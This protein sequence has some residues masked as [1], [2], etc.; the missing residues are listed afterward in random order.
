MTEISFAPTG[1]ALANEASAVEGGRNPPE[2]AWIWKTFRTGNDPTKFDRLF[3]LLFPPLF[4]RTRRLFPAVQEAD[5]EDAVI[6][7]LT[8]LAFNP[9]RYDEKR[10]T[11]LSFLTLVARRR[12]ID[13]IRRRKKEFMGV[14]FSVADGLSPT[15]TE[16]GSEALEVRD[17][18]ADTE[19]DALLSVRFASGDP[20]QDYPPEIVQWLEAALPDPR[21]RQLLRMSADGQLSV[22]EF[23]ALYE[24]GHLP[25]QERQRDMKR[26]RDRIQKRVERRGGD[27]H[28][29]LHDN[30]DF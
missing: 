7:A 13:E 22:E 2:I 14:G 21:D 12:L 3:S 19:R 25:L 15:N 11:L 9:A 24:V 17:A 16:Q 5:I 20:M 30:F 27:L 10:M 26:N 6:K 29:L 8:F 23:A 28:T 1:T 18:Q 4:D